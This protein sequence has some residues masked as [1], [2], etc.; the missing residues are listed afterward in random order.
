MTFD[1]EKPI[2]T[3][4]DCFSNIRS[5]NITMIKSIG[6][7]DKV[8]IVLNDFIER[9]WQISHVKVVWWQLGVTHS[10]CYKYIHRIDCQE[11]SIWMIVLM[12]IE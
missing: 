2:C 12:F 7:K 3:L 9:W 4:N 1:H 10:A 8:I 11:D 5:S 6:N